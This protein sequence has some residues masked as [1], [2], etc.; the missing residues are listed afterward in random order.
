MLTLSLTNLLAR[1]RRLIGTVLAVFLGV[2]FLTGTLV[3]SDTIRANFDSLF[4]SANAG[5]DAVV[6]NATAI[7]AGGG[8][9]PATRERGLVPMSVVDALR[10]ADGVAGVA[11]QVQGYGQ[12]IGKDG[13]AIGG[14][15]PPRVAANWVDDPALTAYRLIEGRAPAADDEVVVNRGAARDGNLRVGDRATVQTPEPVRVRVVGIATWGS[16]DGFGRTTYTGFTVAGAQ[17]Y[18]LKEP[19]Q[20]S[21]IAVRATPGVSQQQLVDRIRPL[22]PRGTE[23]LTGAQLTDETTQ[24]ITGQFLDVFRT[25]LLVF[26]GVALLVATFSIHNTFTIVVAQRTKESALLRALGAARSQILGR[27]GAGRRVVRRADR[28]GPGRVRS[29][30]LAGRGHDAR[31]RLRAAGA[32]HPHRAARHREHPLA[33]GARADPGAGPAPRGRPDPGT[34]A[35]DGALGVGDRGAVR[36]GR[37]SRPWRVPRLGAGAGSVH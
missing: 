19:G 24:D 14:N 3:L 31:D 35:L 10:R 32:R 15:G 28:A 9:G 30:V 16:A 8:R 13:K 5:T 25:F 1:K 2:A 34:A 12:L 23:A 22:L 4:A 6:R 33:L 7:E 18:V 37:R 20:L 17:R 26:A 36:Y 29:L 21:S 27:G 11:P